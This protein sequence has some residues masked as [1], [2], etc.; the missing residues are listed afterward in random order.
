M[1]DFED[2][3][4]LVTGGAGFIGSNLVHRLVELGSNVTVIDSLVPFQGGNMFNLEDVKDKI[5]FKKT[6]I[7]EDITKFVKDKN[8]IFHLA[9]HTS[10]IRSMEHPIEDFQINASSTLNILESCRKSNTNV[11]II[12]TGT[13][14]QYGKIIENPV[15]ESHPLNPL[16][17]NGISKTTA[18]N[19]CMLYDKAY[20]IKSVSLRLT[21]T[22]GPRQQM[23]SNKLGFMTWFMRLALDNEDIKVFGGNQVRDLNFV[24]DVVDAILLSVS[25]KTDGEVLNVGSGTGIS[26]LNLVKKIIQI[27]GSGSYS[28]HPFPKNN[29]NIEIGNHITDITKIKTLIGWRPKVPLEEGLRITF[30]YYKEHKEKYW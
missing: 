20:G 3:N 12:Y 22:Y 5:Q 25:N 14:S 27:A 7:R 26:L 30:D 17:M 29:K 28:I 18:E 9:A 1:I 23:K 16:D 4:C 6:D 21:N 8:Y 2:K 24:S 15:N 13:R 19:Y 10:H 11:K